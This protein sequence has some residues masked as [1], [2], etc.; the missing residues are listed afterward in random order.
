MFGKFSKNLVSV[1]AIVAGTL[2]AC[3]GMASAAPNSTQVTVA[4]ARDTSVTVTMQQLDQ[5]VRRLP[6][7]RG[8]K[9]GDQ[10]T[11]TDDGSVTGAVFSG[12]YTY[13]PP[14]S[15]APFSAGYARWKDGLVAL[16]PTPPASS[17]QPPTGLLNANFVQYDTT[18]KAFR[19]LM[20]TLVPDF[21][22][23]GVLRIP[24]NA[25][26]FR[27]DGSNGPYTTLV[28]LFAFVSGSTP[29]WPFAGGISTGSQPVPVSVG[30]WQIK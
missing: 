2:L 13:Y 24:D 4:P 28:E 5:R 27:Q 17:S 12:T 29:T 26:L 9:A 6:A 3:T 23:P 15:V 22:N 16:T 20:F 1:S 14:G 21:N 25:W 7:L 11:I 10:V 30:F 18:T 19:Q 8:F